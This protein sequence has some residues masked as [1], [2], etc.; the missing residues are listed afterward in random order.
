VRGFVQIQGRGNEHID[1]AGDPM[2]ERDAGGTGRGRE[3]QIEVAQKLGH[4]NLIKIYCLELKKDWL[5]RV[6]NYFIGEVR[7]II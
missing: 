5:F 6:I 3:H 7:L 4:P 2:T 1:P